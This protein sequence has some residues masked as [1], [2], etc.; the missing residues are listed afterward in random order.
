MLHLHLI[1][2]KI[3]ANANYF[4]YRKFVSDVLNIYDNP[5]YTISFTTDL[6]LA[7]NS[8]VLTLLS[9]KLAVRQLH[10]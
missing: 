5:K 7:D 3:D 1:L 9:R 6:Y 8:T 10:R 2:K 4:W